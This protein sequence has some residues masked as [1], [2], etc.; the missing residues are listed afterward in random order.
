MSTTFS[1][2]QRARYSS[3]ARLLH[4]LTVVLVLT[5]IPAGLVMVQD[6]LER[7]VQDALFLYH[8]NIGPVILILVLLRL[9]VRAVRPPPPLP[10]SLPRLQA[11]AAEAVHWLLYLCLV[12]MALSGIVRVQAGGFPM[13]LW[14]PIIGGVVPRDKA[15]ADTAMALHSAVRY[16]LV[17]LIA[18]HVGAAAMHGLIRRDGIFSRMWPPV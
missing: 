8:K 2:P 10:A 16:L 13:E 6:G 3:P 4:W 1:A 14:D 7:S 17:V 11:L 15:V 9:L 18:L 12:T 5:T